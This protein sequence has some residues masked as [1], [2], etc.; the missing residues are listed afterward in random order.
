[1]RS[2]MTIE[3]EISDR[4][5]LPAP[6][7]LSPV[8][9]SPPLAFSRLRCVAPT[10][11]KSKPARPEDGYAIHIMLCERANVQLWVNGRE[12][13]VPPVLKGGV[14]M[15]H[16]EA[17]PV[18]GF[19]SGFDFV[20]LY[21]S[22]ASLDEMANGAGLPRPD[23]LRRLEYGARD[24]ILHHLAAAVAPLIQREGAGDQLLVDHIA[25][26]FQTYLLGAYGGAPLDAWPSRRNL[27]PWQERRAKEFIDAN[28][29]RNVSLSEI[30]DQCGLSASH[31]S[32][33]FRRA[34][35]RPPHRWLLE[36]RVEAAKAMLGE[37]A[38]SLAQIAADCGFSDPSH[39]SRVFSNVVGEPPAVWRRSN[40]R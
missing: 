3:A 34:T 15:E 12:M 4:F 27:A 18:A 8:G 16:L 30:A 35:G 25:L 20:R 37:G 5:H 31:F 32:R 36:R 6:T 17:T 9:R 7:R 22:K 13:R 40:R 33:A 1:M 39:F 29:A 2:R 26:A 14:L 21:V 28:L 38:V 24:P 19:N 23:G 11:R 10:P